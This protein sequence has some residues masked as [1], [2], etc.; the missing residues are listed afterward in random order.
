LYETVKQAIQDV[1]APD[2]E[3]INKGEIVGIKGE[4]PL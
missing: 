1:V 4:W 3:R 2:L